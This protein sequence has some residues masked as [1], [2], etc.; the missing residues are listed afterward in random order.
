MSFNRFYL[1]Y[2]SFDKESLPCLYSAPTSV[3][4]LVFWAK[5]QMKAPADIRKMNPIHILHPT[6]TIAPAWKSASNGSL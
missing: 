5:N 3:S 6:P 4:F 2:I 1:T